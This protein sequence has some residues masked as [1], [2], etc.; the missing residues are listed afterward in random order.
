MVD[1]EGVNVPRVVP[2]S[3]SQ[4]EQGSRSRWSRDKEQGERRSGEGRIAG[5]WG[6]GCGGERGRKEVVGG[7]GDERLGGDEKLGV[8][9]DDE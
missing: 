4:R 6:G 3:V 5:V 7:G 1:G 2:P 9:G 8:A